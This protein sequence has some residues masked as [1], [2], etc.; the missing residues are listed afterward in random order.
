M[1]ITITIT[2]LLRGGYL[3]NFF[4]CSQKKEWQCHIVIIVFI[5]SIYYINTSFL[6]TLLY[7]AYDGCLLTH[8]PFAVFTFYCQFF[9]TQHQNLL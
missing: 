6:T 9:T 8:D 3:F 1:N 4:I 2:P 5:L 7:I